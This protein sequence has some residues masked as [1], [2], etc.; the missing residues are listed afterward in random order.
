MTLAKLV[1]VGVELLPDED[2]LMGVAVAEPAA[3]LA[4]ALAVELADAVLFRAAQIFGG[5][6]ANASKSK[7]V[8][9]SSNYMFYQ[10]GD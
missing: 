3:V 9:S 1:D 8:S 2:G 7:Q 6:A 5:M 4:D 10:E